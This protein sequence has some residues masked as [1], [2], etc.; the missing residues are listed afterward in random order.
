MA[1]V[2]LVGNTTV[3]PVIAPGRSR[4]I[5][6]SRPAE[7]KVTVPAEVGAATVTVAR[8]FLASGAVR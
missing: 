2:L 7:L 6:S 4:N 1:L 5:V 3:S 8:F